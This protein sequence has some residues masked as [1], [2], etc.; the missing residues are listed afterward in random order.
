VPARCDSGTQ[1]D[2]GEYKVVVGI[3]GVNKVHLG[4]AHTRTFSLSN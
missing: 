2:M 4:I 1:S 3:F